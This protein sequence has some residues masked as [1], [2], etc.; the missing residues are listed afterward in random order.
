MTDYIC[1][2]EVQ[3]TVDLS[4]P[5]NSYSDE[6]IDNETLIKLLH[7]LMLYIVWKLKT[8]LMQQDINDAVF[9][10]LREGCP[11]IT[12]EEFVVVDD[13]YI[14]T[15]SIMADKDILEFVQM[16]LMQILMTEME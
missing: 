3:E 5:M 9:S 2:T 6:E 12:S 1:A 4:E 8:Y 15:A 11:T 16:Q 13:Y 14:S 7:F 10:S